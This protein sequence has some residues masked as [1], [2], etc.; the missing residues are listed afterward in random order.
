MVEFTTVFWAGPCGVLGGFRCR[1]VVKSICVL[2]LVDGSIFLV[3]RLESCIAIP[4]GSKV[5]PFGITL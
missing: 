1:C 5:V 3:C 2:L 4:I